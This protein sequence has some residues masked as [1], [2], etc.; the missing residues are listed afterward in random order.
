M[1]LSG[2]LL[3]A[4]AVEDPARSTVEQFLLGPSPVLRDLRQVA[5]VEDE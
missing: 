2:A 3:P 5:A 1:A 4:G